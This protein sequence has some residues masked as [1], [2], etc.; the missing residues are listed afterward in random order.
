MNRDSICNK[1][2]EILIFNFYISTYLL[3]NMGGIVKQDAWI[4]TIIAI[5]L[6]L[7][8]MII[9]GKLMSLYTRK[10]LFE[11]LEIV[12]GKIIGTFFSSIII[13]YLCMLSSFIL[14]DFVDFV[15]ITSMRNTPSVVTMILIGILSI[16]FLKQEM[17]CMVGW[18]KFFLRIIVIFFIITLAFLIPSMR[19]ENLYPIFENGFVQILKESLILMTFP[20][21]E[22]F[23]FTTFFDCLVPDKN[24]KNIFLIGL[25]VSS[26]AVVGF[27]LSNILLL[28]GEA[29]SNTYFSGYESMKRLRIQ[30]EFQRM[31]IIVAT[32]FTIVQFLEMNFC[33]L[34]ACKGAKNIFKLKNYKK[35]IIPIIIIV[36][37]M[38][39]ILS[40]SI[41]D[42]QY[43]DQH[44]W[45][46]IGLMIQII[47]P[48]LI[49]IIS[50]IKNKLKKDKS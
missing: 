48:I 43:F 33:V 31:E 30:G 42:Y 12:F 15:K 50:F 32:A 17:Q 49:F 47:F 23:V 40:I 41:M 25:I 29:Y 2:M 4:A 11:I 35:A 20:F 6:S 16:Y 44:Y 45:P 27:N 8:F 19:L 24:S 3:F 5:V 14:R 39:T 21:T 37:L 13:I 36:I 38:S 10:N 46:I 1:E 18:S 7:P 28:G 22:I 26:F 34:G 9:Y